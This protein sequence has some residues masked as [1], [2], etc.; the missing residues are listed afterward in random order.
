[1]VAPPQGTG[2]ETPLK[3]SPHGFAQD[4]AFSGD[5]KKTEGLGGGKT[6]PQ[7]VRSYSLLV[8]RG[9][10]EVD[11]VVAYEPDLGVSDHP[12]LQSQGGLRRNFLDAAALAQTR[13]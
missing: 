9:G 8:R 3:A 10:R 1:L 7:K 6:R 11:G 13:G 4:G 12:R 5:S 2:E